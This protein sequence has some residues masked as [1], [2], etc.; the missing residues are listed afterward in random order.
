[1]VA[2]LQLAVRIPDTLL[3]SKTQPILLKLGGKSMVKVKIDQQKVET[4]LQIWA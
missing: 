4:I 2:D 3:L 1:M